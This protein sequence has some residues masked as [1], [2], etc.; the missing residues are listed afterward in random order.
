ME[1]TPV[2]T[3][4]IKDPYFLGAI[5]KKLKLSVVN[6]L[7][8]YPEDCRATY[9][10]DG[11]DCSKLIGILLRVYKPNCDRMADCTVLVAIHR[12]DT[13]KG[14]S[15]ADI[16][17]AFLN[18]YYQLQRHYHDGA[19]D[20]DFAQKH[21]S[22]IETWEPMRQLMQEFYTAESA[23]NFSGKIMRL[24]S[25]LVF[26]EYMLDSSKISRAEAEGILGAALP[27]GMFALWCGYKNIGVA[28][29]AAA[30]RAAQ[31]LPPY[32]PKTL[33]ATGNK[34]TVIEKTIALRPWGYKSTL[35]GSFNAGAGTPPSIAAVESGQ[36]SKVV[37]DI[38]TTPGFA[39]A[40][41]EGVKELTTVT[42]EDLKKAIEITP[43]TQKIYNKQGEVT[44]TAS[45]V[46]VRGIS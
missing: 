11:E 40:T 46:H 9:I 27:G 13:E 26:I 33:Y 15:A 23:Y 1:S 24:K 28:E 18:N 32:R 5:S 19:Y 4:E 31:G 30:Y 35:I 20:L 16:M 22:F 12:S 41:I 38:Y 34:D 45:E 2:T 37:S 17:M 29:R 14:I 10:I 8:P 36:E 21:E 43:N 3:P 44:T 7:D 39:V 25:L 6:V 42:K